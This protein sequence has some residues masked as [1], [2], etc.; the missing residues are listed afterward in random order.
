V[1]G[2]AAAPVWSWRPVATVTYFLAVLVVLDPGIGF[3]FGAWPPNP[4]LLP[5]RH[6]S[7]GLLIVA[8]PMLGAAAV[9]ILLAAR[10]R[11]DT[12]V[13]KLLR[14][15]GLI[16]FVLGVP[17]AILYARDSVLIYRGIP[18]E[19]ASSFVAMEIRMFT[20]LAIGLGLLWAFGR[21]A[22]GAIGAGAVPEGSSGEARST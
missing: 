13:L 7:S 16:A 9:A 8:A 22:R 15:C 21:A 14:L 17:F 12:S 19:Q 4:S 20:V 11:R 5:W 10:V 3:V 6:A 1:S 2:A 18:A